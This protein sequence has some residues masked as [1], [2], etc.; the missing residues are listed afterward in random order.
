MNFQKARGGFMYQLKKFDLGTVA[1]YSFL[2]LLILSFIIFL[3]FGLFFTLLSGFLP[4][5]GEMEREVLPFFGGIFIIVM[6]L[7]YAGVGTIMNVL[8]A[9]LY[10][11]LSIKLGGIKFNMEK[12][13]ELDELSGSGDIL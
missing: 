13:A 8:M 1:I 4:E 10:N 6:P 11:L 12:I 2:M 7:V 3:P 5:S 9:L